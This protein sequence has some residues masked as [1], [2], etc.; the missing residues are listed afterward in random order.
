MIIVKQ[1]DICDRKLLYVCLLWRGVDEMYKYYTGNPQ[2]VHK[3]LSTGHVD[4]FKWFALKNWSK[5]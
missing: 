3:N 2:P 5:K 4:I 1:Q